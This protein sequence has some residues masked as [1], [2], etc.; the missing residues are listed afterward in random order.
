L[1]SPRPPARAINEGSGLLRQD[2]SA[3][4]VLSERK[5]LGSLA[6]EL[7]STRHQPAGRSFAHRELAA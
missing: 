6:E 3:V 5:W 4:A 7:A 2:Q 1:H